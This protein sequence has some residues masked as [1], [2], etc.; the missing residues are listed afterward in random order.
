M[1]LFR[2]LFVSNGHGE[3]H[4]AGRILD[5][6]AGVKALEIE[7][8]PMVGEG[9]AYAARGIRR[10]GPR[11][12]LPSRGFATLSLPLFLKDLKAGWISTHLS[13]FRAARALRGRFH[14]ALAVGDVVPM[15]AAVLARLPFLFVG[16]AKSA[17]Y[18]YGYTAWEKALLRRFCL[19]AF[20]RDRPTAGVL[21]RAG[22][23][24]RCAGIP[25]MDDLAPSG[26]GFGAAPDTALLGLL[27]G[28]RHDDLENAATLLSVTAEA[29]G[30]MGPGRKV[31]GLVAAHPGFDLPAF[32]SMM[33]RPGPKSGGWEAGLADEKPGGAGLFFVH[34][35]SGALA[36]VVK[37][38]FAD[39]LHASHVV[40]GLAGT[41]NEQA[42]G[43][44]KPL[45]TFPTPG[46]FGKNYVRM[47][48][49]LFGEAAVAVPPRPCDA[50]R[51][52]VEILNDPA[53]SRR[54]GETG[55][56]RMG[57]PGAS[58]AVAAALLSNLLRLRA[59]E[60]LP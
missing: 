59:E 4:M 28:S 5:R 35:S 37:R 43:L 33:A 60:K 18:R 13:Q 8:W 44:G 2:A 42:V 46:H 11:N 19:L 51:A 24:V 20:P 22:V 49:E 14:L 30:I 16:C 6:L 31:M 7:A 1:P 23:R 12:M 58:D 34:R 10:I 3:D 48:M 27:P 52:V 29:A 39:V 50:A 57:G 15:A 47:K 32:R 21:A 38:R 41:A 53:L 25:M 17:Y 55:R 40:V 54:M 36:L 45:V 9:G 56:G 26:R